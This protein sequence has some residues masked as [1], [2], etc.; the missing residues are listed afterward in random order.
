MS[1]RKLAKTLLSTFYLEAK[2]GKCSIWNRK[3]KTK[4]QNP[5]TVVYLRCGRE[6]LWQ[7]SYFS[8]SRTTDWDDPAKV[9]R[10]LEGGA[11]I[12]LQSISSTFQKPVQSIF[13]ICLWIFPWREKERWC[14]EQALQKQLIINNPIPPFLWLSW[15]PH[16]IAYKYIPTHIPKKFTNMQSRSQNSCQ[17]SWIRTKVLNI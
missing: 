10:R 4:S 3:L 16:I 14:E 9:D 17:E 8:T 6:S 5:E 2:I 7:T 13:T 11:V 12:G 1:G 15:W